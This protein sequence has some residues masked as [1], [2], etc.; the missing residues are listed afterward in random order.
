MSHESENVHSNRTQGR[1]LALK[2]L[3]AMDLRA[4]AGENFVQFAAHQKATNTVRQFAEGLVKGVQSEQAELDAL[5][6]SVAVNWSVPRMAVVDRNVLRIGAHELRSTPE[7]PTNVVIDEA[8]E[9][10]KRY[11]AAQ[12]GAF[13]NGI[14]DKLRKRLRP[15]AQ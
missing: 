10:A 9:L 6:T 7:V 8:V 3:Y 2:Y 11:G 13:I 1:E 4:D 15:G 5:I 12:S 14:L